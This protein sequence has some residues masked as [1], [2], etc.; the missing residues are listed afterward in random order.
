MQI[1]GGDKATGKGFVV[2]ERFNERFFLRAYA[3]LQ[4]AA[5]FTRA[6]SITLSYSLS[7]PPSLSHGATVVAFPQCNWYLTRGAWSASIHYSEQH[8]G[9]VVEGNT[10]VQFSS[11]LF[12][13]IQINTIRASVCALSTSGVTS[14]S[15]R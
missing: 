1:G 9:A 3:T 2:I 4:K 10:L 7:L 14:G 15:E 8:F 13:S 12:D 6:Q 5:T 11:K